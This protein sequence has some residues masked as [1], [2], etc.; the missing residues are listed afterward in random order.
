MKIIFASPARWNSNITFLY[1]TLGA[2]QTV[3]VGQTVRVPLTDG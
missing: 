1:V 3:R 2:P